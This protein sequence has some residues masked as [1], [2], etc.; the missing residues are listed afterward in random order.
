MLED[1]S[2]GWARWDLPNF[3]DRISYIDDFPYMLLEALIEYFET[4]REQEVRFDAEGWHYFF[5]FNENVVVEGKVLY[6]SVEE[7]TADLIHDLEKD[8][9]GWADFPSRRDSDYDELVRL[10]SDLKKHLPKEENAFV[11]FIENRIDKINNPEID[12]E[13]RNKYFKEFEEL[14]TTTS[15]IYDLGDLEVLIILKDGTNLTSWNDVKDKNDVLYVSEDVSYRTGLS[16]KYEKCESLESIVVNGV[17]DEVSSLKYMFSRCNSLQYVFGMDSWDCSNLKNMIGMFVDCFSLT[18]ISFLGSLNVSNV[19]NMEGMFQGCISLFDISPLVSWD[20]GKVENMH[21]MF[22]LC[23]NLHSLNGLESWDV[24]N[25]KDMES[26]FHQCNGLTDISYLKD[27]KLD[28]IENLFEMFR[29]C[30][31]LENTDVLNSW[32]IDGANIESMFKNS[33]VKEPKWYSDSTNKIE[34]HIKSIDD[35][36]TLID[37]AYNHSDYITRKFAVEYITDEDVLKDIIKKTDDIGVVEAAIKN[38]HL[39]DEEFLISQLED[40]HVS[41]DDGGFIVHRVVD[42][43][44]L[45]NIAKGNFLL[46]YRMLA[47]NKISEKSVLEEISKND[48]NRTIRKFALKRLNALQKS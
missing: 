40:G 23:P 14:N 21:A 17:T 16:F 11:K 22:A 43:H 2:Y 44:Y 29:D 34:G 3:R 6:D 24:S 27:W 18:D 46:K 47:I 30:I 19:D 8:L 4:G 13:I 7:F 25:V 36:E 32:D 10:I 28:N 42:E 15:S 12:E 38:E 35:E 26:M 41:I 45:A 33:N 48:E 39:T 9:H 20:V 1:P 5:T 31:S 37:I